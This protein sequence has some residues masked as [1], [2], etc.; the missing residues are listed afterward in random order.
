[1]ILVVLILLAV[2]LTVNVPAVLQE[3]SITFKGYTGK[4]LLGL[5]QMVLP[6]QLC[7]VS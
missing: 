2:C 7:N 1:M 3:I 6:R 4:L 5:Q